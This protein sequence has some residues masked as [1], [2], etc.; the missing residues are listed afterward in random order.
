MNRHG[1]DLSIARLK[2]AGTFPPTKISA[3]FETTYF[4]GLLKAGMPEQ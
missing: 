4:A 2:S 1:G 3:P